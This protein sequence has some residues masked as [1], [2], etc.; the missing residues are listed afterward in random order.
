[1]TPLYTASATA[2]GGRSGRVLSAIGVLDLP[3]TMPKGLGGSGEPGSNPEQR[4]GWPPHTRS[5]PIP[6]LHGAISR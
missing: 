2:T 3:L 1:M 6:G 4:H 5:A